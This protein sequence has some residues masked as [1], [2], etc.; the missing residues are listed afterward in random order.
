MEKILVVVD[1]QNDFVTGSLGSTDAEKIVPA[2]V[3]KVQEWD[4]R[5]IFT[6]D[7]HGKDYMN[8]HE[9]KN[10]PVEHCIKDT[11][12]WEII[13]ELKNP[14]AMKDA[15]IFEKGTF[16]STD[17]AKFLAECDPESIEFIGLCTDICVVSNALMARAFLP[18]I[19]ITVDQA[20][21]AGV[22]PEKHEASLETMRSCQIN[23]I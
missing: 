23:V 14:E 22:T 18:E 19:D 17:L 7:T 16:G 9:G 13:D 5:V 20:C 10:L 12:G 15:Q 2:V 4:G 3:K 11:W 8:T 1:M 21:C 6:Q